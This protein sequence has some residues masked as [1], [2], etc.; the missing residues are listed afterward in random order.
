MTITCTLQQPLNA[1][2]GNDT[3]FVLTVSNSAGTPVNVLGINP[4]V[5]SP[6]GLPSTACAIGF[7]AA[8][9]GF[10][11]AI[12]GAT[13]YNVPVPANGSTAFG[14][15][16][17]FYGPL[18]TGTPTAPLSQFVVGCIVNSSD[19]SVALSPPLSV[20]LNSPVFG[21]PPG[22]PPNAFPLVSSLNFSAPA[23]SGLLL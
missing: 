11:A 3:N 22:S 23:N 17:Q 7:P 8:P 6:S 12:L 18:V 9:P 2:A 14:F 13:Q 10:S 1:I 5:K 16:I 19:G 4:Y 20:D 15:S 21:L